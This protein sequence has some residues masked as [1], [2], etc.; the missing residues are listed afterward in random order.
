LDIHVEI[1]T[2]HERLHRIDGLVVLRRAYRLPG[3]LE[4]ERAV[5]AGCKGDHVSIP[6]HRGD[7]TGVARV[8]TDAASSHISRALDAPVARISWMKFE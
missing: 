7:V 6:V 3:T 2:V 5:Q 4:P 1:N 8:I